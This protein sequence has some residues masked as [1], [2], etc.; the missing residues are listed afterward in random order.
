MGE[1]TAAAQT[2]ARRVTEAPDHWVA[3]LARLMHL[4]RTF[5]RRACYNPSARTGRCSEHLSGRYVSVSWW[6]GTLSENLL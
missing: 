5:E 1:I 6:Y 4:Y 2:M 3:T